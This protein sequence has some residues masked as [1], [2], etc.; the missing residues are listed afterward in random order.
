M[1]GI[2]RVHAVLCVA[3][4]CLVRGLVT[5]NLSC[6]DGLWLLLTRLRRKIIFQTS[7]SGFLPLVFVGVARVLLGAPEIRPSRIFSPSLARYDDQNPGILWVLFI[8]LVRPVPQRP[9]LT[10]ALI[11]LPVHQQARTSIMAAAQSVTVW[12]FI[13]PT[14][15]PTRTSRVASAT[16]ETSTDVLRLVATGWAPWYKSRCSDMKESKHFP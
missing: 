8:D 7:V 4:H 14:E 3:V 13:W 16:A 1:E 5:T 9:T 11:D 6:S 12:P 10:I 15:F 2:T